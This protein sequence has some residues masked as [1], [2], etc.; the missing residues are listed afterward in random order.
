MLRRIHVHWTCSLILAAA[1]CAGLWSSGE[2]ESVNAND[3]SRRINADAP[4]AIMPSGQDL[5]QRGPTP[6]RT[7]VP[8]IR[9]IPRGL[10]GDDD[11]NDKPPPA[12]TSTRT[13]TPT[14]TPI[15]RGEPDLSGIPGIV[16]DDEPP[17]KGDTTP[18]GVIPVIRTHAP[19][20]TPTREGGF[21]SDLKMEMNRRGPSTVNPGDTVEYDS[22]VRN[23]GQAYTNE[24]IVIRDNLP[25]GLLVESIGPFNPGDDDWSCDVDGPEIGPHVVHCTHAASITQTEATSTLIFALKVAIAGPTTLTHTVMVLPQGETNLVDN[26]ARDT[27]T[28]Q[29]TAQ[30]V[31]VQPD[32]ALNMERQGDETVPSGQEVRFALRVT[33]VG[34]APATDAITVED[35]LP[36]GL[37]ADAGVGADW[38]C[39]REE[40]GVGQHIVRCTY[41]KDLGPAQT[42]S[43][44][45]IVTTVV[46]DTAGTLSNTATVTTAGDT[47]PANNGAQASLTVPLMAIGDIVLLP[48]AAP[49]LTQATVDGD[50]Q[51]SW[52]SVADARG[53]GVTRVGRSAFIAG[54]GVT[55]VS[56]TF[57]AGGQTSFLDAVDLCGGLGFTYTVT[58]HAG[59]RASPPSNA[60]QPDQRAACADV[61]APLISAHS[62]ERILVGGAP[63]FELIVCNV[64]RR[65]GYKVFRNGGLWREV[66]EPIGD[67]ASAEGLVI[68]P[69]PS[70]IGTEGIDPCARG[71]P[72]S[73]NRFTVQDGIPSC[74]TT[75]SRY[76]AEAERDGVTVRSDEVEL[77]AERPACGLPADEPLVPAPEFNC[78]GDED[79]AFGYG[80]CDGTCKFGGCPSGLDDCENAEANMEPSPDELE[81]VPAQPV[82]AEMPTWTSPPERHPA[83]AHT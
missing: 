19:T 52:S 64:D 42:S 72:N 7:P 49:V 75:I 9:T 46:A 51:L 3:S 2:T 54:M 28:V 78:A 41:G 35:P 31:A 82:E 11:E 21:Q 23:V 83:G 1:F 71:S 18:P 12:P 66:G 40:V 60:V 56:D 73:V 62:G 44:L 6:T 63:F 22:W 16:D 67:S 80:C 20:A 10:P 25:P 17:E 32:L 50:V 43:T 81:N 57:D 14:S 29:G 77:R 59:V 47:N 45:F 69:D 39:E 58:A 8:T 15:P 13:P 27:L 5:N 79:C 24:P 48:L 53:Y 33:N 68:D 30:T 36:R 74:G 76:V 26:I 37:R 34:G 61:A 70:T 65:A 4:A 55:L 38:T